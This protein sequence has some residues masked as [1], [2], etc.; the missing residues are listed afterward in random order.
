MCISITIKNVTLYK[1]SA[2]SFH[3]PKDNT[4]PIMLIGPGTGI[5]PFRSFWQHWQYQRIQ[6]PDTTVNLLYIY[7]S[8]IVFNI[9][10][11]YLCIYSYQESRYFS[12]VAQRVLIS[13]R[14]RSNCSS[15]MAFWTKCIWHYRARKVCQR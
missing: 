8:L 2:S 6:D 9:Y 14:T 11:I 7:C 12:V 3:L 13:T 1:N 10:A 15:K 5:A 4:K